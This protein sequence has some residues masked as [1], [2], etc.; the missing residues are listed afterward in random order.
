MWRIA[1]ILFVGITLCSCSAGW[2]VGD[3]LPHWLGGLPKDVPPR[4][5]QPGY[6]EYTRRAREGTAEKPAEKKT[7]EELS[8]K[9]A[10]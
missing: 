10:D 8:T 1:A 6:E 9:T 7:D 2:N 3:M 4:R 5:G